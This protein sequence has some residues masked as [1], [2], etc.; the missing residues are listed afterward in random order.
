ME[1]VVCS[2]EG[3]ILYPS[4]SLRGEYNV[5]DQNERGLL[6]HEGE[7][8]V[9]IRVRECWTDGESDPRGR[10]DKVQGVRQ[11]DVLIRQRKRDVELFGTG[12]VLKGAMLLRP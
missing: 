11:S 2:C 4:V 1:R 3:K 10:F 7:S 12:G 5:S 9:P 6:V 8:S